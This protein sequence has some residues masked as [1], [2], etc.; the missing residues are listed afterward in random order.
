MS[1]T[2]LHKL[3]RWILI[4]RDNSCAGGVERN[5]Y[6][7]MVRGQGCGFSLGRWVVKRLTEKARGCGPSASDRDGCAAAPGK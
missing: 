2:K 6:G 5:P 7:M 3:S 4:G 1:R